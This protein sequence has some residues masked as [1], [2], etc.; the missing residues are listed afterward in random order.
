MENL[1]ILHASASSARKEKAEKGL[2]N[3]KIHGQKECESQTK[4]HL[5]PTL[6]GSRGERPNFKNLE[7]IQGGILT[8][9][10]LV[11]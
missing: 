7:E 2:R 3:K 6:Q 4:R 9:R 5:A 11:S 1:V 8:K 10:E